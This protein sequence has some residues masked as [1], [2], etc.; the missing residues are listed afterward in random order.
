MGITHLKLVGRG[1]HPEVMLRDIQA[2]RTA[3]RL[4][5]AAPTEE[6]Y[7][8]ALRRELFPKGCSRHCY[9]PGQ[10]LHF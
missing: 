10:T 8:A 1:N 2:L 6:A 5:E 7:C 9:Y 3:V 4:A